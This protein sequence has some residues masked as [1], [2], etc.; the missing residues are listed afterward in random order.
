M[1]I[2][3]YLDFE[4]KKSFLA[5]RQADMMGNS[6]EMFLTEP[7]PIMATCHHMPVGSEFKERA[8]VRRTSL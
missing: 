4:E 7:M 8:R 1:Q 6:L 5:L 3:I 2:F